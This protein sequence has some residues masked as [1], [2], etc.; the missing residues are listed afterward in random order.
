[1]SRALDTPRSRL[2]DLGAATKPNK[3][4]TA[5]ARWPQAGGR[6][7]GIKR[8]AVTGM[9][10]ESEATLHRVQHLFVNR[11]NMRAALVKLVNA[12]FAARDEMW[13]GSGTACASDGR[14][15]GSWSSNLATEWHQRYR[16]PG[17][18]IYWHVERKPVC[19]YSRPKS[20]SISKV[21]S[22]I[23]GVLR[24]CTGM[25]VDRQYTDTHGRPLCGRIKAALL[26]RV[27]GVFEGLTEVGQELFDAV[28][29]AAVT[30]DLAVPA[31]V[32]GIGG[33]SVLDL[34]SC[35]QPGRVGGR[36]DELRAGQVEAAL[37]GAFGGQP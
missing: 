15:F 3:A 1:M 7:Q 8:V 31:V 14:K 12:T 18:M 5:A 10:G 23:E 28:G 29:G 34:A 37:A 9:H 6:T 33:E 22:M 21:S 26:Q 24:H 19:I 32:G 17:V 16:G 2:E 4:W 30:F 36:G 11:T 13:W 25:E 20:C 27:G 35:P